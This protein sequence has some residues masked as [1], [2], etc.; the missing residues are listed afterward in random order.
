M[1]LRAGKLSLRVEREPR[2]M[3]AIAP[4][5]EG[6]IYNLGISP[7]Q[8]RRDNTGKDGNEEKGKMGDKWG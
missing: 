6:C 2:F 5:V 3:G 4:G 1:I 7:T 8:Q